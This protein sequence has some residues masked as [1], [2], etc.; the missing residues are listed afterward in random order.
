MLSK[1]STICYIHDSNE[2]IY[3]KAFI[4]S[5]KN[6]ETQIEDFE[7]GDMICLRGKFIACAGWFTINATSIKVID[8]MDFDIMPPVGLSIM[9]VGITTKTVSGSSVLEFYVKENLED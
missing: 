3:I 4:P 7:K 8:G 5:D 1:I 2:R 9:L 6:I